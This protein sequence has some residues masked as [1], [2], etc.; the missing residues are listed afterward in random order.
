MV[1]SGDYQL[2]DVSVEMID[3]TKPHEENVERPS[4]PPHHTWPYRYD[5]VNGDR[6]DFGVRFAAI[7]GFWIETL[8]LR[9]V[10]GVWQQALKVQRAPKRV[11]LNKPPK[12]KTVRTQVDPLYPGA[13]T[14]SV[15]WCSFYSYG[16]TT[17][18]RQPNPC[19]PG[20]QNE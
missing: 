18:P 17:P 12:F 15:E 7:N 19:I 1:V 20:S 16:T 10:N 4:V 8:Q 6:E 3:Y 14:N 9:K 2:T 13:A 11:K 5:L